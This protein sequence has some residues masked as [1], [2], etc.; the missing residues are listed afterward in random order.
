MTNG[1]IHQEAID[2][3]VPNNKA[4]NYESQKLTENK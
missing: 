3:Y 4:S 1:L 2:K